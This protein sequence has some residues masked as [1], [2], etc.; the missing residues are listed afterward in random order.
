MKL[1]YSVMNDMIPYAIVYSY[2]RHAVFHASQQ[3]DVN[4]VPGC[5]NSDQVFYI[6]S[7]RWTK[8]WYINRGTKEAKELQQR[9]VM[10]SIIQRHLRINHNDGGNDGVTRQFRYNFKTLGPPLESLT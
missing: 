7:G 10:I 5:M 1:T 6:L 8:I 3:A 9:A 2:S 4:R